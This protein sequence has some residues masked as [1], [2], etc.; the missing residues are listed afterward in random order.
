[1]LDPG[2]ILMNKMLFEALKRGL[3]AKNITYG[4]LARRMKLSEPTIKRIFQEKDCKFGR[5]IEICEAAGIEIEH[6]IGSMNRAPDQGTKVT[7]DVQ[8]RLAQNQSL[9]FVFILI[10]EKFTPESIMRIH[11]LS[12]ASMFLYLRDLEKLGLLQIGRGL[13]FRLLVEQPVQWDFDGPLHQTFIMMNRNFISWCIAHRGN[14]G[15]FISFSRPMRRQTADL[16]R[17]EA[18]ELAERAKLLSHYDQQT[19]AEADL[20]GYKWAWGFGGS[21]FGEMMHVDP[22]PRERIASKL[23]T[24]D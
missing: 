4:D 7:L 10:L 24:A 12:E 11:G 5:L 6:L 23:A 9:F 2:Y 16:L 13:N 8:R 22:H 14:D 17:Q 18:E 21:P 15:H 19:T 20:V 3:K 1:M